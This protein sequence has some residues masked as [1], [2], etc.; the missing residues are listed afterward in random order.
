M[1]SL[2]LPPLLLPLLALSC[3]RP[4]AS[5]VEERAPDGEVWLTASQLESSQ[6]KVATVRSVDIPETVRLAGRVTFDD[7]RVT[8]V[9]S[10]VTGR[11]T[12]IFASPGDAVQAGAPLAEI[13]SPD[14]G[15]AMADLLKAQA[16]AEAA[17]YELARQRELFD[18]HAAPKKDL[19]QASDAAARAAAELD[20]TRQKMR[21]LHVGVTGPVTQAFVLR[22][23]LAGRV[24]TRGLSPGME[25]Q[26]QYT[27]GNV[28]E[29]FTIGDLDGVWVLA[30][31]HEMDVGRI[32]VGQTVIASLVAFPGE[33]F[34]GRVTWISDVLDPTTHT[35]RV[36]VE[37]PNHD[38]KLKPEMNATLTVTV[39][40]HPS[41]VVPR[42]AVL[43]LGDELVV[44]VS[45][46]ALRDGR[47]RF[48]R[49]RVTLPAEMPADGLVRVK[50]GLEPGAVVVEQGAVLLSEG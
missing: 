4:A 19:E 31:V 34:P 9:F 35:L 10:P 11:V 33:T 25:V 40:T 6:V 45:Q 21:L 26:G 42:S 37:L 17:S 50:A 1:T 28:P 44:Y 48:R 27:G 14:V 43:R 32:E 49:Q 46:G 2:H 3:A 22:S 23:P 47:V 30:D 38:R 39:D 24:V 13:D 12:R 29:L 7:L 41:L 36:R 5:T 18:V 16:D 8:H 20:R 15:N